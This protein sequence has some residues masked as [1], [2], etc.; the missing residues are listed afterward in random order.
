MP[1][2]SALQTGPREGTQR[3][4]WRGNVP[5]EQ[6]RAGRYFAVEF[7]Y[8]FSISGIERVQAQSGYRPRFRYLDLNFECGLFYL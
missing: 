6:R 2:R 7:D 8:R 3:A 4:A 5:L 1:R